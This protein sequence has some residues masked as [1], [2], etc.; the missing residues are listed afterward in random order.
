MLEVELKNRNNEWKYNRIEIHP[1]LANKL[2]INENGKLKYE[3]TKEES[4]KITSQLFP[5]Y[6]GP[7]I[8][9][10][11]VV[12]SVMITVDI[13]KYNKSRSETIKLLKDYKIP[14]LEVFYGYTSD[15]AK[16]SR[17]YKLMKHV[18]H[19]NEL[20]VGM[21]E[22]FDNFVNKYP[23]KNAWM[24]Y[25]EDDVR[26]INLKPGSDVSILLNVPQDAELIRV[27]YGINEMTTM[28]LIKYK[29]SYSGDFN[30]ALYISVSA[31]KKVLKYA[32][33]HKWTWSCDVDLYKLA[34]GAGSFPTE[35]RHWKFDTV[36]DSDPIQR[37]I[38][39]E[40]KIHMYSTDHVIFNQTSSPLV[41]LN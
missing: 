3:L 34:V 17:F 7:T 37:L 20:T 1:L 15:S 6:A 18:G 40:D 41:P 12:E 19:R 31:C 26:I 5:I 11:Q 24:L 21:L 16:E 10:I 23:D 9:S 30:H 13:P 29:K 38:P 36:F 14:P 39:E 32:K 35:Y 2:L 8:P 33:K 27:H 28:E 22:I 25:L 4:N